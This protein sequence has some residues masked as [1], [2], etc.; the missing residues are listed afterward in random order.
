MA[1]GT[2]WADENH[3]RFTA[4][5]FLVNRFVFDVGYRNCVARRRTTS[6]V[7]GYGRGDREIAIIGIGM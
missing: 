6:V 5:H 1:P 7:I 4:H 2:G 3:H